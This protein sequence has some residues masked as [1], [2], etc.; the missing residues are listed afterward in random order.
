MLPDGHYGCVHVVCLYI[1]NLSYLF[2]CQPPVISF[3]SLLDTDVEVSLGL[4]KVRLNDSTNMTCN[5]T[6][7]GTVQKTRWLQK[8]EYIIKMLSFKK[9]LI[10]DCSFS[11]VNTGFLNDSKLNTFG[12]WPKQFILQNVI[13]AFGKQFFTMFL[14]FID[15]IFNQ[16]IKLLAHKSTESRDIR[17]FR[18]LQIVGKSIRPEEDLHSNVALL[19]HGMF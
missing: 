3:I 15:Q 1:A 2:A 10:K 12:L 7:I 8:M 5:K 11:N 19:N 6:Y 14:Y 13:L 9:V 4:N 18:G 16:P 17:M